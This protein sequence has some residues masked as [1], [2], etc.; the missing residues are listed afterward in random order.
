MTYNQMLDSLKRPPKFKSYGYR[1]G[2]NGIIIVYNGEPFFSDYIGW[3]HVLEKL[4]L[5]DLN[6]DDWEIKEF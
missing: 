1:N 3:Y 4:K 5:E 6:A 2:I